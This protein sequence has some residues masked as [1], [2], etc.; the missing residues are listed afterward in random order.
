MVVWGVEGYAL[1]N[2]LA[3]RPS[4][5]AIR[6]EVRT[7]CVWAPRRGCPTPSLFSSSPPTCQDD[8]G[9]SSVV[10]KQI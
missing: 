4:W 2:G 9:C 1:L 7:Y 3:I 10:S 8:A 6:G 5:S